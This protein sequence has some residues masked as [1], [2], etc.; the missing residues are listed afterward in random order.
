MESP[1]RGRRRNQVTLFRIDSPPLRWAHTTYG[2]V[3]R[4]Q[5]LIVANVHPPTSF[6]GPEEHE[7]A[8]NELQEAI[9]KLKGDRIAGA[10][11]V[12]VICAGDLNLDILPQAAATHHQEYTSPAFTT[13][14]DRTPLLPPH[15]P[16]PSRTTTSYGASLFRLTLAPSRFPQPSPPSPAAH[17]HSSA[18]AAVWRT[19]TTTSLSPPPSPRTGPSCFLNL[20]RPSPGPTTC[21]TTPDRTPR[22]PVDPA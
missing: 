19:A 20:A 21:P 16:R 1:S 14:A 15:H 22:A 13:D 11:Q 18:T 8:I 17:Q 2:L 7:A 9:V 12:T 4:V 5:N 3:T 6:F 10:T